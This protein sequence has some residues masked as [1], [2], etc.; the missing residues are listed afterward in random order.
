MSYIDSPTLEMLFLCNHCWLFS[1]L[2]MRLGSLLG[3][4]DLFW[5]LKHNFFATGQFKDQSLQQSWNRSQ[6][7]LV[8]IV[9]ADAESLVLI[10]QACPHLIREL[11]SENLRVCCS[12]YQSYLNFFDCCKQSLTRLY[13]PSFLPSS[14]TLFCTKKE[15]LAI[16]C[17]NSRLI[18][19]NHKTG[20]DRFFIAVSNP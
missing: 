16:Y 12:R 1:F 13:H 2:W 4:R 20:K 3:F 14:A 11:G 9:P 10:D 19:A 6:T 7:C 8:L 17:K 15:R 18:C 5:L